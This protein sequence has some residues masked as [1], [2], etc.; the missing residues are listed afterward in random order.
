MAEAPKPDST[1]ILASDCSFKG[2]MSFEGSMRI[3][4]RFEG[5]IGSKG[6]LAVGK[7]AHLTADVTVGQANIDGNL[8]G[9][10]VAAERVELTSSAVVAADLRAPKLVVAEGATFVGNVHVGPDALKGA[11]KSEFVVPMAA[12]PIKK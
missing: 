9:N 1:T 2:E 3:D 6:R 8:K 11:E 5:K 7:G 10:I 12:T 4:G